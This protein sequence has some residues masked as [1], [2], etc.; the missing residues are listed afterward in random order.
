MATISTELRAALLAHWNAL[1]PS[2]PELA[3]GLLE[4][5]SEPARHYHGLS[6]LDHVLTVIDELAEPHHDRRLVALAAWYHD[7]IYQLP[8]DATSNEEA[9]ARLAERELSP[10]RMGVEVARLVRL[11]ADHRVSEDDADGALLCDAD[12]AILA[13]EPPDYRRYA[14]GIRREYGFVPEP[15]FRLGRAQ[16]LRGLLALPRL[17][18]TVRGSRWEAAARRNLTAEL[19][20]L[21]E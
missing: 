20:L 7:A 9:S 3:E 5:W 17:F 11:T 4:R 16:V 1:L 13:A 12:L 8:P 10:Y 14:A 6:H 2:T 18:H 21:E 19:A 15:A